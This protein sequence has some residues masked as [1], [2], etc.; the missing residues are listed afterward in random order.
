IELDKKASTRKKEEAPAASVEET[1]PTVEPVETAT[2]S[3]AAETPEEKQPEQELIK[4][5][6][7]RLKGLKVV[8]KI[9]LPVEKKKENSPVAS[10]DV[11]E[12]RKGKRPRKRIVTDQP[13]QAQQL[14][15]G[16]RPQQQRGRPGVGPRIQKEEPSEK[17]IQD[18]IKATL[19][20]LSGGSKKT[21]GSKYRREKQQAYTDAQEQQMLQDEKQ[22]KTLRVSE[23]IS[24][25]YLAG[26][27][28]VYVNEVNSTCLR[29]RKL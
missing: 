4:A 2:P 9:E 5:K 22:S 26:F 28:D 8:D 6:A 20:K 13:A 15:R 12:D 18:Q 3:V 29:L 17:E 25:I 21:T 14:Q 7:D 19:A 16:T 11:K 27:K 23:F 24:T 10:S 1:A